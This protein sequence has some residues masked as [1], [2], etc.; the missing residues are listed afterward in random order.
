MDTS[1]PRAVERRSGARVYERVIVGGLRTA[2]VSRR[3]LGGLM[4]GDCLAARGGRRPPRLVFASNGH[5][6]ALA[7]VNAEFRRQLAQADLI[8]ADGTPV[9][10]ASRLLTGTPV[11]ERSATTDFIFDAAAAAARHGLKFFLLGS[12]E[13]VNARCAENLNTAYPGVEIAGRRNGYFSVEEEAQ[14]CDEINRSGADVLW[15]GLGVPLE[16]EFCLRNKARL[17]VG[18]IV[19]CGGCFNFAAGDYARAPQWMQKA[20]FEWLYRLWREPKRLFWRYLVTNPIAVA[21]LLL[22]TGGVQSGASRPSR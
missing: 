7:A 13:A 14:I 10:F 4:V 21:M 16:Y 1:T 22:S 2:C 17:R 20:G 15:V 8:H 19:T 5:A 12:T 18:W 9:V 11:P 6:I 3:Q